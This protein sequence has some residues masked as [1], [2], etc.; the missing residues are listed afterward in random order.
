MNR[1]FFAAPF[2]ETLAPDGMCASPFRGLLSAIRSTLV[3]AGYDVF[4]AHEREK[5]GAALL[6]ADYCTPLDL[7][8]LRRSE[9]VVALPRCSGGVHIELGW[10]S[11]LRKPI[12]LLLEPG[13]DY[14][15][16]V[17]GLHTVTVA[18]SIPFHGTESCREVAVA[19]QALLHE[20]ARLGTSTSIAAGMSRAD[21]PPAD[22]A[23]GGWRSDEPAALN[24]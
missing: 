21:A 11:A 6:P 4:L 3:I 2:T 12:L 19:L 8:E 16:L 7:D 5:W 1:I 13:Y 14:S 10:A 9:A 22:R 15:P 20:H 23:S 17:H 24:E 18:K